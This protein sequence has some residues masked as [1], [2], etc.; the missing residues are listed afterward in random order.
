MK[1]GVSDYLPMW[2]EAIYLSESLYTPAW[3]LF[4]E[5]GN[6]KWLWILRYRLVSRVRNKL[7]NEQHNK[8]KRES[9]TKN[10][11]GLKSI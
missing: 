3:E 4:P 10:P 11:A 1:Y 8:A 5:Y 6:D 2:V 7:H 9:Q